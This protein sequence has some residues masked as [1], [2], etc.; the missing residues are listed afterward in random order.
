[1]PR[2]GPATPAT[3]PLRPVTG[4]LSMAGIDRP[5]RGRSWAS[6]EPVP[7]GLPALH[8]S[9]QAVG[10]QLQPGRT[11]PRP[12]HSLSCCSWQSWRQLSHSSLHQTSLAFHRPTQHSGCCA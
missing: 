5:Q 7:Q 8:N 3:S 2:G 10:L 12:P 9:K 1:M 4:S 11:C 6:S